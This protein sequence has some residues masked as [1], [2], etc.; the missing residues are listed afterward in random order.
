MVIEVLVHAAT[1]RPRGQGPKERMR[2]PRAIRFP[3]LVKLPYLAA[4]RFLLA[5]EIPRI[6][7]D[8]YLGGGIVLGEWLLIGIDGLHE[9]AEQPAKQ[10]ARR[11]QPPGSHV[12][13]R[14]AMRHHLRDLHLSPLPLGCRLELVDAFGDLIHSFSFKQVLHRLVVR[15][16]SLRP[17]IIALRKEHSVP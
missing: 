8:E 16:S 5:M 9:P 12:E 7:Y 11:I 10:N 14:R 4:K 15:L 3:A 2:M 1:P 6:G 17:H 13:R